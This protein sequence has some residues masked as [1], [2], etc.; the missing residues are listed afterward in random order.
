MKRRLIFIDPSITDCKG[1][2]L[3]YAL[4]VLKQA[5]KEGFACVL[6]TNQKFRYEL[7]DMIHVEPIFKY[8]FWQIFGSNPYISDYGNCSVE[9]NT[10][11]LKRVIKC[12]RQKVYAKIY[13]KNLKY[14]LK[15]IK[16]NENDI[17]FFPTVCHVELLTMTTVIRKLRC[18][19]SSIHV[20]F[21]R[22]LYK[23]KNWKEERNNLFVRD[24]YSKFVEAKKNE[25]E[26]LFF[27]TDTDELAEQYNSLGVYRFGVLPIPHSRVNRHCCAHNVVTIGYLG[28]AR[29]EKGFCV[30]PSI[31]EK[32][33]KD[34]EFYIQTSLD[35][36][37]IEVK[38]ALRKLQ[39]YAQNNSN[40][41][42]LDE[43]DV[44]EYERAIEQIDILLVLYDS[45]AYSAR[46]SGIFVEAITGGC[47]VLT[48]Y[49]TWM[50]EQIEMFKSNYDL[51]V[52]EICYK[53]EDA[54]SMLEIMIAHIQDYKSDIQEAASIYGRIHNPHNL[55]ES[56]EYA[57]R[58]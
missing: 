12:W 29:R 31:V 3:E 32:I 13:Q 44:D 39:S 56:F 21:R 54:A 7:E 9:S 15:K 35:E 11:F 20:L 42:L 36:E 27:F 2:Y 46:S 40:I 22:P 23:G 28:G 5:N 34:V 4:A 52:G 24:I 51:K 17:I 33:K 14:L 37:S 26:K 10:F 38:N 6:A 50:A 57:Q 41:I 1:H 25:L 45:V 30:L 58:S 48:M 55:L 8:T 19:Y 18:Q 43:L 49:N 16:L 53:Q 47:I